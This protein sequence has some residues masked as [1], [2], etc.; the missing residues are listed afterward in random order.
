MPP[1]GQTFSRNANQTP[2][3]FLVQPATSLPEP[4]QSGFTMPRLNR[5]N[6]LLALAALPVLI[7]A[8]FILEHV[9]HL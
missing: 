4:S 1:H 9:F 5:R 3:L 2:K 7:A 6:A 8:H